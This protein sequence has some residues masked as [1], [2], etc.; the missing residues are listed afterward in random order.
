MSAAHS[1]RCD[2][3]DARM[4]RARELVVMWVNGNREHV[5]RV[6]SFPDGSRPGKAVARMVAAIGLYG[7][8]TLDHR[9]AEAVVNLLETIAREGD[10][11]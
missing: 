4:T 6:L 8:T 1:A 5:L 3:I 11:P 10:R 9:E 2:R 7:R